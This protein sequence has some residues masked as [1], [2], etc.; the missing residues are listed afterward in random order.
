MALLKSSMTFR[1]MLQKKGIK[2]TLQLRRDA[3]VALR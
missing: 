2:N 3:E 1:S